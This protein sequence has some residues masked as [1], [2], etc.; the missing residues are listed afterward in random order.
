VL[1][2]RALQILSAETQD[3]LPSLV[4]SL[5]HLAEDV[6]AGFEPL[7]INQYLNATSLQNRH[8]PIPNPFAL[9]PAITDENPVHRTPAAA[10]V[11]PPVASPAPYPGRGYMGKG[12][13]AARRGRRTGFGAASPVRLFRVGPSPVALD[14]PSDLEPSLEAIQPSS[15]QGPAARASIR[16]KNA[17]LIVRSDPS[18]AHRPRSQESRRRVWTVIADTRPHVR[19]EVN[20]AAGHDHT[21]TP[22]A[23]RYTADPKSQPAAVR[24]GGQQGWLPDAAPA[25]LSCHR[26]G[27]KRHTGTRRIGRA[28]C[29]DRASTRCPVWPYS[30]RPPTGGRRDGGKPQPPSRRCSAS[31]ARARSAASFF[32]NLPCSCCS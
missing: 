24:I 14:A 29:P 8:Q 15:C 18:S 2:R 7:A 28:S 10:S 5:V 1:A 12:L 31:L 23:P 30:R 27:Q 9:I 3:V 25:G 6:L 21:A 20:S 26:P 17:A 11:I 13:P 22:K 4:L 16:A 32:K 19:Q